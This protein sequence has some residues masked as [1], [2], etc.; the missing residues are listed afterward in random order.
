MK[1]II[2]TQILALLFIGA[3]AQG[4]YNDGARIVSTSGSYW[5]VDNDDF[6]LTS[7]SPTN[8]TQ[9]D[10]LKIEADAS[11][12]L[13]ATTAPTYLSLSGDLTV[14]SGGSLTLES[15]AN[16]TSSLII[17]G[18][19]TGNVTVQRFL[20]ANKWHYISGQT[21]IT[22]DFATIMGLGTPGSSSN[23]FY[24]WDE[25]TEY[26]GI[27]GTW[28]DILNGP[29]GN[30][31]N[32]EMDETFVA[33]RGYAVTYATTDK[34]LSLS[35]L[36][37][38]ENKTIT[39]TNSGV[40]VNAGSNLVGNPFCSNIAINSNAQTTNNFIAQ[41]ASVLQDDAQAIYLWDD[42]QED[43][44]TKNNIGEV[45]TE[46]GQAF[47]VF[48]KNES[49]S[50][51]FNVS[52]QKHGSASF[53]KSSAEQTLAR[54]ELTATGP[55]NLINT[56]TIAFLEGMTEGLDPSYDARKFKGNLNIAL[57]T[58]LVED[59][60]HDFAIQ[61]LPTESMEN[62][63][64]PVGIDLSQTQEITFSIHQEGMSDRKIQLEDRLNNIFTDM[65][66]GTYTAQVAENSKGRFF[67][68]I[69]NTTNV[70]ETS[71]EERIHIWQN[72]NHIVVQ[73]NQ[74]AER[75]TLTDITGRILG[76]WENTE[77]IPTPTTTGVYLVTVESENQRITK[78]IT[79]L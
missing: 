6:T 60:G 20:T 54:I 78:K 73:G 14:A 19:T 41:N 17:E 62:C 70:D 2:I 59:N 5:V 35:G 16:G 72:G 50:L 4:I 18:T 15:T 58:R 47:M 3:Y 68:H 22:D 57:Y 8:L 48:A 31:D 43:Y 25:S 74:T 28:I 32:N 10:N 75:I 26:E 27:P 56:S 11:L 53:Y 30:G 65:Q 45:Y 66:N 42:T 29:T 46:P 9:F 21:N 13:D 33:C 77:N 61:A 1:K 34:T 44:V 49:E 67:L 39:I 51:E 12:T 40:R 64:V 52:I 55:E 36:P 71:P 63:I 38:N 79:I 76:V 69:G 23:S 24:R 37:Y 7:T